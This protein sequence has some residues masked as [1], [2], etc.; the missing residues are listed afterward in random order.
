MKKVVL[1]I[2]LFIVTKANTQVNVSPTVLFIDE[3]KKSASIG[4]QNGSDNEVEIWFNVEYSYVASNDSNQLVI[5]KPE[6]ISSD[7]KSAAGWIKFYPEKIVLL[8]ME[9]KFVRVMLNVPANITE[10][11]Y[12]SRVVVNSKP[13]VKK[14][15]SVTQGPTKIGFEITGEYEEYLLNLKL[16]KLVFGIFVLSK[17]YL[18]LY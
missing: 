8:P 10:G 7:D 16:I 1:I 6:N 15:L 13:L 14:K 5:V 17:F 3:P 2:L 11:E 18:V 4:I 9:K 12:W